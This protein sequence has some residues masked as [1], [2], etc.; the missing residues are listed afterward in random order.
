VKDRFWRG[1]IFD[2][3]GLVLDSEPTYV[4]AWR[5][6]ADELGITM[7][8]EFWDG[9]SGCSGKTV[10]QG[11]REQ[12]GLGFNLEKF[13]QLSS[14]YW[15]A[16]VQQHGIAVKPGFFA[17]LDVLAQRGLSFCLATNS[18][19][20][21]AQQCLALAGL[22]DI[23]PCIVAGD[24]VAAAKPAPDIFLRASAEL[25]QSIQDCLVLEDSPIGI[26]A[27]IAAGAPCVF[28]PSLHPADAWA[29]EH[30]DFLM[31]DLQEVADFISA[32][33]NHPL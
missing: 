24:M 6:A 33:Q 20:A 18:P 11:L 9:L 17:L 5:L 29:V 15:L 22:T 27:A 1:L 13:Q 30:A 31:N 10:V 3:D 8:S 16:N 4:Q 14:I 28:V 12:C 25:A 32:R 19:L 7:P 2:M 23:F 21:A 26:R